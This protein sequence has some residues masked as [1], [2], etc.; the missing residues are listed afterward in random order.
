MKA[1]RFPF[2]VFSAFLFLGS[3][4][5]PD[6]REPFLGYWKAKCIGSEAKAFRI[7]KH[8]KNKKMLVITFGMY[9]EFLAKVKGNQFTIPDQS[10]SSNPNARISG[11]GK[12][13]DNTLEVVYETYSTKSGV[14]GTTVCD[15]MR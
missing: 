8:E 6:E 2:F 7:T 10:F 9:G 15:L 4:M 11:Y 13:K 12:L 1:L 5:K 3:F 14:G